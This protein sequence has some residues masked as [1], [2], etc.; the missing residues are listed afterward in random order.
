MLQE[1]LK[2]LSPIEFRSMIESVHSR[3]YTYRY[4]WK[5]KDS[6]QVQLK[7]ISDVKAA[8]DLFRKALQSDDNVV[9]ALCEYIGEVDPMVVAYT[10]VIK[11]EVKIEN[12]K[13]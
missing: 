8:H 12:E 6:E 7:Y 5:V 9:S 3:V 11:Q 13:V 10:D 4:M 2:V 1:E